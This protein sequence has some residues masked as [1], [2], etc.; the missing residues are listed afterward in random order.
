[1]W[2]FDLNTLKYLK[3]CFKFCVATAHAQLLAMHQPRSAKP[4][5]AV[6]P[7]TEFPLFQLILD[8]G[9]Q[10]VCLFGTFLRP[11]VEILHSTYKVIVVGFNFS[12]LQQF[13]FLKSVE[14]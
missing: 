4:C 14:N 3:L 6:L 13:K 10:I 2:G 11:C 12:F 1:M 5:T 9:K 8:S 7:T